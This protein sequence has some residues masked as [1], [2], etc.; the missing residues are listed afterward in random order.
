MPDKLKRRME[1]VSAERAEKLY[2]GL[3][4][5]SEDMREKSFLPDELIRS[6]GQLAH[7]LAACPQDVDGRI[8]QLRLLEVTFPILEDVTRYLAAHHRETA[9]QLLKS[10]SEMLAE[11]SHALH[12]GERPPD[13]T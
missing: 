4:R 8:R 12:P 5:I 3:I 10:V 9:A 6:L 11:T 7:A 1:R 13:E 2:A